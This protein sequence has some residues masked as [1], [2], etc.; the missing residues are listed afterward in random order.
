MSASESINGKGVLAGRVALISGGARGIG[1]AIAE[2]FQDEGACVFVLDCDAEA[3]SGCA[4][5]LSNR[6]SLPPTHF[7]AADLLREERRFRLR[8]RRLRRTTGES[9]FW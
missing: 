3:G 6:H 2:K 1:R 7:V 9:T 5:E 4:Q 8:S